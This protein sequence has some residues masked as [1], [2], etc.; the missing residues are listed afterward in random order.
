MTQ[1]EF[2]M[3]LRKLLPF[4][5]LCLIACGPDLPDNWSNA[6]EIVDFTQS[7]CQGSPDDEPQDKELEAMKDES[8]IVVLYN[9]VTLNCDTEIEGFQQV[10]GNTISV[11]LQPEDMNPSGRSKCIC[12][13]DFEFVIPNIT[14]GS[15]E[16][17]LFWRK[18]NT[19]ENN[20]PF[21]IDSISIDN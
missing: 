18:D 11:L 17:E 21:F 2:L 9:N 16:V 6:E 19:Q 15:Y 5:T 14:S 8:S 20:E 7:M 4:T 12:L 3:S 13:Y 10:D 1:L